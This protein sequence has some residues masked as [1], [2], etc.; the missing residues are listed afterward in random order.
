VF[1]KGVPGGNKH[2]VAAGRWE[3]GGCV[4]VAKRM[5]GSTKPRR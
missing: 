1:V 5:Q 3:N 2:T 4:S